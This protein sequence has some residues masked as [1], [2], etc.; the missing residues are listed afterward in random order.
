MALEYKVSEFILKYQTKLFWTSMSSSSAWKKMSDYVT[1][2]F[3]HDLCR[4]VGIETGRWTC[5]MICAL[6][7]CKYQTESTLFAY[8]FNRRW[9]SMCKEMLQITFKT[10][11][12]VNYRFTKLDIPLMHERDVLWCYYSFNSFPYFSKLYER[13]DVEC[14]WMHSSIMMFYQYKFTMQK[15]VHQ[16][17]IKCHLVRKGRTFQIFPQSWIF[18]KLDLSFFVEDVIR[19]YYDK[20]WRSKEMGAAVVVNV[21]VLMTGVMKDNKLSISKDETIY[22]LF[23]CDFRRNIK[24]WHL[25]YTLKQLN[26]NLSYGSWWE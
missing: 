23:W 10:C 4:N 11:S 18:Y 24:T 22:F 7:R 12:H 16:S 8:I 3:K 19:F 17:Q 14:T 21:F 15:P 5:I 13:L 25:P 2:N 9:N 20:L 1:K 26:V 6:V